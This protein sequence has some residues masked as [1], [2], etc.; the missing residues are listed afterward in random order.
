MCCIKKCFCLL[1]QL[2]NNLNIIYP[3]ASKAFLYLGQS[4]QEAEVSSLR[5][6]CPLVVTSLNYHINRE[7][8]SKAIIEL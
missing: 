1:A 3:T 2:K 4:H 8:I 6:N 7:L 5:E